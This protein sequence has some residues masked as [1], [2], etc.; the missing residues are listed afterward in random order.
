MPLSLPYKNHL[1]LTLPESLP[2]LTL[3]Q[4]LL[5]LTVVPVQIDELVVYV[6]ADALIGLNNQERLMTA[7]WLLLADW[8]HFKLSAVQFTQVLT[9]HQFFNKAGFAFGF[10]L[11]DLRLHLQFAKRF[12]PAPYQHNQC[13]CNL[14]NLLEQP[15]QWVNVGVEL[16]FKKESLN[17]LSLQFTNRLN[18]II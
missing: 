11:L 5:A 13:G 14:Y 2:L 6:I 9:L 18:R 3:T 16:F 4:H 15:L 1:R 10:G 17:Y 8:A 12:L 7:S